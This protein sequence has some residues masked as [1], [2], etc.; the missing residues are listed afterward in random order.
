MSPFFARL[1]PASKSTVL[2]AVGFFGLISKYATGRF[3]FATAPPRLGEAI[4]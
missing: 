4:A 2:Y 3:G 1:K